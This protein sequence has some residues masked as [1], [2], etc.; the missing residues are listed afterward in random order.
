MVAFIVESGIP[1]EVAG[2]DV[3]S[4]CD[5]VAMGAEK[6]TPLGGVVVAQP[7][8][9]LP[10]E[11]D[12]VRPDVAGVLV[13][14]LHDSI[15]V[16]VVLVTEETVGAGT[17][18][19]ISHVAGGQQLHAIAGADVLGVSASTTAA[20]LDERAFDNRPCHWSSPSA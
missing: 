3:H 11:G 13:Q 10:L 17:L 15:H 2:R 20:A 5:F 19:Q 4:F 6:T 7:L 18:G 12:D 14:L 8:R 9:I 1:A 16:Y